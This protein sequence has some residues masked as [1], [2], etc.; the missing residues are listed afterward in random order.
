MST[1]NGKKKAW[2]WEK[3][4]AQHVKSHIIL[5]NLM[6]C[7]YQ[8]LNLRFKYQFLLNGIR[9]DKLSTA[10]T[11]VRVH[12]DKYKKDFDAVVAFL[13]QYIDKRASTPSVKVASVGHNKLAS[14]TCSI[15]KGKI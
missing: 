8:G 14:A 11:T 6:K 10:V 13:T 4:V 2:N 1:Y 7:G 5:G 12:P 9:C 3:Y 15:F